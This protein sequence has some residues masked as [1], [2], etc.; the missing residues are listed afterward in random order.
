MWAKKCLLPAK[1]T[2][3]LINITHANSDIR[4]PR[5]AKQKLVF[6]VDTETSPDA[7]SAY[8]ITKRLLLQ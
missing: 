6:Q 5:F 4:Y 1:I 2:V 8:C 7:N 3:S